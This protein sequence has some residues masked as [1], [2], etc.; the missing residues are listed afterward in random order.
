ML[1]AGQGLKIIWPFF[2]GERKAASGDLDNRMSWAVGRTMRGGDWP[3]ASGR[4]VAMLS[5]CSEPEDGRQ[6]SVARRQPAARWS[7]CR[8]PEGRRKHGQSAKKNAEPGFRAL[9]S[10]PRECRQAGILNLGSDR[11]LPFRIR[12]ARLKGHT[13]QRFPWSATNANLHWFKESMTLTNTAGNSLGAC[14]TVYGDFKTAASSV[15]M[16]KILRLKRS[17]SSPVSD[18]IF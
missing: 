1:D 3:V 6:G 14:G 13:Q 16:C 2:R 18:S 12:Y 10:C 15:S 9:Q 5:V 11:S 4:N 17:L 8:P 7:H